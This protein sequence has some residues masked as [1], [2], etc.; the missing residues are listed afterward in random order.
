MPWTIQIGLVSA[1]QLPQSSQSPYAL[2]QCGAEIFRS[3]TV[4]N[5]GAQPV[6]NQTFQFNVENNNNQGDPVLQLTVKNAG[7]MSDEAI[8]SVA[9]SLS[10]L[11]AASGQ[12]WFQLNDATTGK[13][14]GIVCL[15]SSFQGISEQQPQQQQLQQQ[16]QQQQPQQQQPQQEQQQDLGNGFGGGFGN[17]AA[18]TPQSFQRDRAQSR[19]QNSMFARDSSTPQEAPL[20][21]GWIKCVDPISLK[22]Y[23]Q[24]NATRKTQWTRP[25]APAPNAR[26]RGNYMAPPTLQDPP[27][28]PT[29]MDL[30]HYTSHIYGFQETKTQQQQVPP[31]RVVSTRPTINRRATVSQGWSCR[32]CTFENAFTV[33]V[34]GMC[35]KSRDMPPPSNV[36]TCRICTFENPLAAR[37]CEVCQTAFP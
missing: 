27:T 19:S 29:S 10:A 7:V 23:Y 28:L 6:F 8:G 31:Q 33:N 14:A 37:K 22:P 25:V 24:N 13:K 17:V 21:P 2:L 3:A 20:A 9:L 35:G 32:T 15:S 26:T 30:P 5:G 34:C 36:K 18:V 11:A 1:Q 16:Q 4:V 12:Q